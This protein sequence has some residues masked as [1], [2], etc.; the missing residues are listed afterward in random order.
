MLLKGMGESFLLSKDEP[1]TPNIDGVM[2]L[3]IFRRRAQTAK[4]WRKLDLSILVFIFSPPP[5]GGNPFKPSYQRT[6]E[7][8]A[9]E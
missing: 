5:L 3:W 8:P 4:N 7:A 6:N 1:L 9:L 2:A